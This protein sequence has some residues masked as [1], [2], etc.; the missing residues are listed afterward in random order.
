MAVPPFQLPMIQTSVPVVDPQTGLMTPY[1]AD[2]LNRVL[3]Q[4]TDQVNFIDNNV[5]SL[6][7]AQ[8]QI[9]AVQQQLLAVQQAQNP[10][11]GVHGSASGTASTSGSGWSSSPVV[12]LTGVV[13]GNL[14]FP[15][16]GPSQLSGTVVNPLGP[17]GNFTGDWRIQEIIAGVE[18]T[19]F[20]GAYAAT[21]QRDDGASPFASTVD[22]TSSTTGSVAR[23]TTGA[24][25]YRL[26]IR[27]IGFEVD[28]V[29][30]ALYVARS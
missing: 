20:S 26:D 7:A 4:I 29:Q 3:I 13:A 16:S 27:A 6:Q 14:T 8:A 25:D 28:N 24:I 10:P 15:G 12:H 1:F 9:Q 23:T 30:L 21:R 11:S 17:I 18:T 5:A 22:N 2:W 19:V